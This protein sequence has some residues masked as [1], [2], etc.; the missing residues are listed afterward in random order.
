MLK[1]FSRQTAR[2]D[3]YQQALSKFGIIKLME[4]LSSL[5]DPDFD[6]QWM[7]LEQQ[8][9]ES[10]ATILIRQ[11]TNNLKGK[12][13]ASYLNAI[14][15]GDCNVQPRFINI[16]IVSQSIDLP[17][18]FP[19]AQVPYFLYGD[20]LRWISDS[21]DTDWGVVVGRFYSFAPHRCCWMWGYLI[22]LN[23]DSPSATRKVTD[24]VWE[25][26]LKPLVMEELYH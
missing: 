22:W 3:A 19:D 26:E 4:K 8:E 6:S 5:S 24:T 1:P 17:V 20:Q 21:G 12:L 25:E 7:N 23:K 10:L 11:L 16:E 2:S 18:N 9:L 13:I 15:H 14:R